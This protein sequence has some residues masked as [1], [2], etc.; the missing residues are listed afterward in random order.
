M[1][2]WTGR[3]A[4]VDLTS[5]TVRM[6]QSEEYYQ[7]LGGRGYGINVFYNEIKEEAEPFSPENKVIFATGCFTGTSLPGASR[8]DIVTKNA[9]NGGVSYSSVGG[10]LGVS[11]KY[12]GVDAVIVEGASDTP[13][14][15]YAHDGTVEIRDASKL[16]GKTTW[17]TE[18]GIRE[19]LGDERIRV[20]AIGQ[21]GENLA[22]MACVIV[23]KAHAAAWGGCGA[24]LGSKKVKALAALGRAEYKINM[25]DPEAFLR[26][27]DKYLWIL[28]SSIPAANLKRVGTH[29]TAGA[30]GLTGTAPTSVRNSLDEYWDPEKNEKV[31]EHS[32]NR[33]LKKRTNCYNCPIY[34]MHYYEMEYKGEK[35]AGEGMHANSVRGFSSNWDVDD[36]KGVFKAHLLCNQYGMD[37]D[38]TSST[39]AFAMECFENGLIDTADTFGLSLNWG[40]IDDAL[41]LINDIAYRKNFGK[42]LGEGAVKAAEAIG[43]GSINHVMQAKGVGIN[44]Q[45]LRTH[46]AWAFSIGVSSRGSGHVSGAPQTEK[47]G[48]APEICEWLFG[49]PEAGDPTSY[50]GKAKLVAWYEV[51]KA[52]VDSIGLCYFNAGWYELALAD[53]G[54]YVD[55]FNSMTGWNITREELWKIGERILNIEKVINIKYANLT[56]KDDYLPARIMEIPISDGKYKG[57]VMHRDRYDQMLDEYYTAH[58]WD[59]QTGYP[60]K[61]KLED[62]GLGDAVALIAAH[63]VE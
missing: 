15:L 24:I 11:L 20:G 60:K 50:N 19:E 53:I 54:F 43:R 62:L 10:N 31:R 23:D 29:G 36:Q 8:I 51:Y 12:A 27:R 4:R 63:N 22:R 1:S 17:D 39:I 3:I 7:W 55:L 14:Y 5:K 59:T 47:R 61:E 52:I 42:I 32:Y 18:D 6:E 21:A 35:L 37:V 41:K 49:C 38:G 48:I 25:F 26:E 57:E 40:N 30:G 16:W 33:Y 58:G 2:K 28:K 34:C 46:K 44:E 56:R 13:V 9:Y 45:S